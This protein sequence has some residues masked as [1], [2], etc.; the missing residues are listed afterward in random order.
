MKYSL[1]PVVCLVYEAVWSVEI[2]L[3]SFAVTSLALLGLTMNDR[4][5]RYSL[6]R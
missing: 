4:P 1:Q 3:L 6:M 2:A 5:S